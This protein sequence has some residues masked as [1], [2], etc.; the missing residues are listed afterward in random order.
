MKTF[1]PTSTTTKSHFDT[2]T[3]NMM[4]D[5]VNDECAVT[6]GSML[7]SLPVFCL[8]HAVA[9]FATDGWFN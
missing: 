6:H 7:C 4:I 2:A 5:F 3:N 9:C 1:A 8:V